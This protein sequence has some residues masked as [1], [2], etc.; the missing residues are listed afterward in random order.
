MGWVGRDIQG[1]KMMSTFV[2]VSVCVFLHYLSIY[3]SIYL[4]LLCM[5]LCVCVCARAYNRV[6]KYGAHAVGSHSRI[7]RA[8]NSI[9]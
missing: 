3:L 7:Q 6:K 2:C 4:S 1:A 9:R 5:R 8:H